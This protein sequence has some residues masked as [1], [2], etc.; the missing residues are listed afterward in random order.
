MF[1]RTDPFRDLERLT[2][3]AVG[4]T[5][6]P[7]TIPM[8]A[9]REAEQYVIEFDLPGISPQSV[10]LDIEHNVLTVKAERPVVKQEQDLLA[11]ER[12][13]GWFTRQLMLGDTLESEQAEASYS[14]GVLRVVI[15]VSQ[16]SK[17]RK[18]AVTTQDQSAGAVTE[19]QADAEADDNTSITA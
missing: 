16:K 1:V 19:E 8:D 6:S 5:A 10:D 12:P 15:P 4:T 11:A 2:Q 7:A 17:P 9:W 13:H 18:I 3:P 14:T